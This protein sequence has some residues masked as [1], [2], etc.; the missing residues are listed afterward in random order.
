M[1][2]DDGSTPGFTLSKKKK[3]QPKQDISEIS[4][5]LGQNQI[6]LIFLKQ[7]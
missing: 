6:D 4:E 1:M 3:I 5:I 2:V 7:K